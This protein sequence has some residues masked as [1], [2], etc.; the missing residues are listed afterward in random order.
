MFL[1]CAHTNQTFLDQLALDKN[2]TP[3]VLYLLCNAR[4]SQQKIPDPKYIRNVG[5]AKWILDVNLDTALSVQ[6]QHV[7]MI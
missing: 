2:M 4:Q 6:P 5:M 1:D 3:Q 7:Q